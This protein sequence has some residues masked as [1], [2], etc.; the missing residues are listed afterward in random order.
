[1]AMMIFELG[2]REF[3]DGDGY[4]SVAGEDDKIAVPIVGTEAIL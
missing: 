3:N 2:Q 4:S 1:M